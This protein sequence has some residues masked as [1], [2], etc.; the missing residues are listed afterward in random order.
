MARILRDNVRLL[1]ASFT[2]LE[3]NFLKRNTKFKA[4]LTN[5]NDTLDGFEE[6]ARLGN[7]LVSDWEIE[8][9]LVPQF[10][11]ATKSK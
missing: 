7:D 8:T 3:S 6:L 5:S 10:Q 11:T 9:R 4:K 1:K 2:R